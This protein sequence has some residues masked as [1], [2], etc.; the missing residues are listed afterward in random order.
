MTPLQK[1]FLTAKSAKNAKEIQKR[2][3]NV[4]PSCSYLEK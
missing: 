3:K 2:F 4:K 1:P